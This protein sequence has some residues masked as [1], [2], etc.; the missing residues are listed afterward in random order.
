MIPDSI[1]PLVGWRAWHVTSQG[2]LR[3]ERAARPTWHLRS[4]LMTALVA[5]LRRTELS[6]RGQLT[7]R[8]EGIE[9]SDDLM[10]TSVTMREMW[11]GRQALEAECLEDDAEHTAPSFGCACGIWGFAFPEVA[12]TAINRAGYLR[13]MVGTDSGSPVPVFGTVSMWGEIVVCEQGYRSEFAYPTALWVVNDCP[14]VHGEAACAAAERLAH[15]GVPVEVI[16]SSELIELVA[17]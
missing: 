4:I 5:D 6:R 8:L 12:W 1:T 7:L 10:L 16:S 14:L 3:R 13:K 9:Q 15:Y 11:P 2:V 17:A